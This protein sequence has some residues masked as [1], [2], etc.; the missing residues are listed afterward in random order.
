[1]LRLLYRC[2]LFLHPSDFRNRFQD[3]MLYIFDHQKGVFQ[4]LG[5]VLDSAC[6]VLR[7]WV[8]RPQVGCAGPTLRT[9]GGVPSF[10]TLDSFRP[11][12]SAVVNGVVLSLILFCATVFA[13]R[14]SWIH[15]LHVRIHEIA[16]QADQQVQTHSGHI[17]SPVQP[18][19]TELGKS[20][21]ISERLQ[22]D[23]MPVDAENETETMASRRQ[24]TSPAVAPT[25]V[26]VW[27]R[28]EPYV[29]KYISHSPPL[30][31]SIGIEGDH[32]SIDV[33]G[34]PRRALSSVSQT[35]FVIAN[36]GKLDWVNFN[37]DDAGRV[38]SLSLSER[39]N[40]VTAQ[41]R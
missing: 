8:L 5:L 11:R 12:T 29:G 24:R 16:L 15:V 28:L 40:L 34:R 35:K 18:I 19:T 30:R 6:S 31:I 14:Y 21:L 17:Q 32:L 1:M 22:V 23:V 13:I 25:L 41:R 4:S 3:E 39:G 7:Q 36:T 33:S 20:H 27:L 26:A 38:R 10:E 9:W 37:A 2:A